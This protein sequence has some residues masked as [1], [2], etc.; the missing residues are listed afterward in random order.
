MIKKLLLS[1]FLF[2]TV[3]ISLC[4]IR[5]SVFAE[6]IESKATVRIIHD[7]TLEPEKLKEN[8]NYSSKQK[9]KEL[10]TKLDKKIDYHKQ[11]SILIHLS[12]L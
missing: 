6:E 10:N 12:Q 4:F 11:M 9:Y 3:S 1:L 5:V 2:L 8:T 7:D